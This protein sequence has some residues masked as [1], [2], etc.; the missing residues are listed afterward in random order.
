MVVHLIQEW[1]A[2]VQAHT[3]QFRSSRGQGMVEYALIIAVVA[4]AAIIGLGV[5]GGALKATFSNITNQLNLP[6]GGATPT[7]AT[8]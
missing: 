3:E 5:L 2:F 6:G 8:P 4:I 1:T 7:V